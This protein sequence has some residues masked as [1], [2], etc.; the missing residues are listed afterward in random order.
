MT[1]RLLM[2]RAGSGKTTL[3]LQEMENE[4]KRSQDGPSLICL[5]PEQNAFQAEYALASM[6]ELGG[7][8]RAQ[9]LSY[10]R[11]A[12]RVLQETGGGR[13]LFIDDTGKG[14]MLCK[15]MERHKK[16]LELFRQAGEKP[17]IVKDLVRLYNE[18]RRARITTY[19]LKAYLGRQAHEP[20][21]GALLRKKLQEVILIMEEAEEELSTH[22]VD[23][24]DTLLM[25]A[26]KLPR[27]LFLRGASLWV[28]GFYGFTQLEFLVLESL[29]RQVHK[30]TIT[31]CLGRDY[32]P[33]EVV[34]ELD[35]FYTSA[36]TCQQLQQLAASC[37]VAVEKTFLPEEESSPG[38]GASNEA[39]L[40]RFINNPHLAHLERHL[41]TYPATPFPFA[42][43]PT[44]SPAPLR[45]IAAPGRRSEIEAVAREIITLVRDQQLRFR[46]IAVVAH[47]L[48]Q[49]E[50]LIIP[51]FEDFD[52]PYFLD[53]K[54]TVSHHP[55][56]EF[57]RSA[58]EVVN[59]NWRP[60]AVFRCVKSGLLFP[61]LQDKHK[62]QKWR[63]R[64]SMLENYVLAFGIKGS[65]WHAAEDWDYTFRDTM[66]EEHPTTPADDE[67][68]FLKQINRLR[69][70][71]SKPLLE[72]QEKYKGASL[73]RERVKALYELLEAVAAEKHLLAA[74][75]QAREQ[76]E[77]ERSREQEQVYQGVISLM[78]QLVEIMGEE[79]VSASFFNRLFDVGLNNLTL[80]TVPPSLDQVLVGNL[81]RTRVGNVRA[82]FL[83]GANDGVLPSRPG[84]AAIF[85]ER[86][87][88]AL[89][90]GGFPLAPGPQ[91]QLLD[92]EFL[93]YMALTRAAE[94]LWVSYA[95]ADEEGRAML[96]ALLV[97]RLQELFPDLHEESSVGEGEENNAAGWSAGE[98]A[99]AAASSVLPFV[100]HPRRTLA[101]L[102]G[103]L[104]RWKG[105]ASIHP[106]WWDVYNWFAGASSE[107]QALRRLLNGLFYRNEEGFL[108][109]E[110]SKEL[111]GSRLQAGAS[112]L[113]RFRACPFSHFARYGLR[114]QER[115]QHGIEAP[116]TGRF[117]HVVLRNVACVL[118]EQQ[119]HWSDCTEA[120]LIKL[121][122]SEVE[123]LL[124]RVKRELLLSSQ[125]YRH[126]AK[127]LE[128]TV[129]Q[130]V[131]YL[132]EHDRRSDFKPL[133]VE[134]AFGKDGELPPLCLSL[135]DGSLL[136][137]VGRIDRLD[138]AHTDTGNLYLRV[139]DYKSGATDLNPAEIYHGI[140]LQLLLYLEA[141]LENISYLNLP[142]HWQGETVYPAG[143]FYFRVH[144]PLLQC[145]A[146][147]SPLELA[148]ERLKLYKLRGRVLADPAVVMLMDKELQSGYSSVLPVGLNKQGNL[149]RT[150]K[151]LLTAE[152][153]AHLRRHVRA[154]TAETAAKII[155]GSMEISPFKLGS[156]KACTYCPYQAVCQFDLVLE[157]N[158]YRILGQ[159]EI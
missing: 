142:A 37:G 61:V 27:S 157:E 137:V 14:M 136:E 20:G 103:Q 69:L 19:Q 74:A 88:E 22:Y 155:E 82:L 156:K 66:E 6:P 113:E 114:L 105:G 80:G 72:F 31:L 77:P 41:H 21:R 56:V 102:A 29:L 18:L 32:L 9:V 23:A 71:F 134:I 153:F 47:N 85:S 60:D 57:I 86:E 3:C 92:E 63:D 144:D 4:L 107:Q 109:P 2:G 49:Y 151:S 123:G 11:L 116:D 54:R 79:Q 52:I 147:P 39:M 38:L 5:V 33:G 51:V 67:A 154:V 13:R 125:R 158:R 24:E 99:S 146:P 26:L 124:P 93:V 122:S 118:Q 10:R 129:G 28:D 65:L 128:K 120:E 133:G 97:T 159:G 76:G 8:I 16:D 112:R 46:E 62:L 127:K 141:A 7:T 89:E 91:R 64:A 35:P 148:K 138:G 131:L 87:R 96:P 121:V 135:P 15:V 73:V 84:S 104:G 42:N 94:R 111:Y 70:Y 55:L 17:G 100:L 115:S 152:E 149:Y 119:R 45:L 130:A 44:V 43:D 40:P 98:A 83:M 48:E 53:Q 78:D 95:L 59:S 75:N 30:L 132:A 12:W 34:D 106:L 81:E 117:F 143:V 25:L 101:A 58:L 36:V 68:V 50:D 90:G 150:G 140:S 139:I 145:S 126:L 1:L 108:A 110:T